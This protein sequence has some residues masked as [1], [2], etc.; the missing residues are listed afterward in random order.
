MGNIGHRLREVSASW[1]AAAAGA[2]VAGAAVFPQRRVLAGLVAGLGVLVIAVR[3]TPCC[4]GCAQGGGCGGGGGDAA[5]EPHADDFVATSVSTSPLTSWDDV[6]IGSG[7]PSG[8]P[9]FAAGE[10]SPNKPGG[11]LRS[12]S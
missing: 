8:A 9:T 2:A 10:P 6:F 7:S 5:A 3:N 1:Y 11:G 12:C 4:S